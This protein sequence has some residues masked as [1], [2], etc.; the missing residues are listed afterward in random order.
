M[1]DP[2][3][4]GGVEM[5][6]GIFFG[7]GRRVY[8]H[9]TQNVN[10]HTKWGAVKFLKKCACYGVENVTKLELV[11]RINYWNLRVDLML[12]AIHFSTPLQNCGT[13]M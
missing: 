8:Y 13:I 5:N 3:N 2:K 6:F 4:G 1:G 9:V 12:Q 11:Q 7:S 10:K